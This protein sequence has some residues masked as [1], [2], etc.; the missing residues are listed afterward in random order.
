MTPA[1]PAASARPGQP[2]PDIMRQWFAADPAGAREFLTTWSSMNEAQQAIATQRF[3]AAIPVLTQALSVPYEQRR[4]FI[5]QQSADLIANG[6]SAEEIASFDPT[7]TNTQLMIRR[8]L[9]LAQQRDFFAPIEGGA[10]QV[11]RDRFSLGVDAANPSPPRTEVRYDEAGNEIIATV[12]GTPAI[13]PDANLFGAGARAG[14]ATPTVPPGT[15]ETY[16]G[17]TYELSPQG[18]WEDVTE[19]ATRTSA[20]PDLDNWRRAGRD[21][22]Q[23]FP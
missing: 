23:T 21:G 7:D 2:D 15:R 13:G 8:G 18:T 3:T 5:Q 1:A 9:P 6:W 10:G 4:A 11:Y 19:G 12:P 22:P 20:T 16:N 14:S 17:R